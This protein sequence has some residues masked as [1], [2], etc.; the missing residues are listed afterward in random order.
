MHYIITFNILP[1]FIHYPPLVFYYFIIGLCLWLHLY[2]YFNS[3][4]LYFIVC[5]SS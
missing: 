3:F 1:Q 4:L 5:I 2:V